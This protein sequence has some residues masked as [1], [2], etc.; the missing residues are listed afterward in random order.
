MDSDH[1]P[2][3]T[4]TAAIGLLSA[5]PI[6]GNDYFLRLKD[7][8]MPREEFTRSQVHF[9]H[10]VGF[11]SRHLAALIARLPSSA[12]RGVLV[13]NL[14]EEHGLDEENPVEDFR[15]HLA[16][17]R[18]FAVFLQTLGITSDELAKSP[19]ESV[20][21]SFNLALF[22]ACTVEPPG[23]AFAALGM[24]EY[25]FADISALIGRRVVELGWVKPEEL[26]HYSLHAEIDKRHAAELFEAAERAENNSGASTSILGGLRFG[27]YIFDRLYQDMAS[28]KT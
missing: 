2:T 21:R 13:H 16:H 8:R 11:F 10:A 9:F 5:S 19:P 17:D 24:I 7:G 18:T 15:P 23:F 28:E 25:A 3:A 20:V 6:L 27:R 22:G 12:E 26:V 4:E 1:S 14:S